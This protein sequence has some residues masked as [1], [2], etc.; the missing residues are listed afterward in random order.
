MADPEGIVGAAM[1]AALMDGLEPTATGTAQRPRRGRWLV[2]AAVMMILASGGLWLAD[3]PEGAPLFPLQ[4]VSLAGELRHVSEQDLRAAIASH[5]DGGL[6]S[7]DVAGIR[8]AVETLPW[9][10]HASVRRIWPH[11]LAIHI[12]E[13]QPLARW[14]ETALVNREGEVFAPASRPAGLPILDG[15]E[16]Q[17]A[18]VVRFYESLAPVL[19][20]YDLEVAALRLDARGAW[21]LELS[22]GARV[23]LGTHALEQRL[24]R[25]LGALPR[26]RRQSGR[27]FGRVD[28]RYPNGFAIEWKSTDTARNRE[29]NRAA[30]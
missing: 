22:D 16:L 6:L 2:A 1:T 10:R 25:F 29:S 5:T 17:R 7:L 3:A 4:R 28:L 13:Q 11:A 12:E 24:S 27:T 26:L 18:A 21:T 15:P 9:V 19:A 20:D 30:Q 14:G 23:E 8:S